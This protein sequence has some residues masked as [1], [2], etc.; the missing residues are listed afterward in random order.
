MRLNKLDLNQLIVLDAM[1]SERSVKRAAERLFLSPPAAS[2][3]LARLRDYFKDELL[4]Q[5][6]KTMVLTPKAESM[7]KPVRDVL[8]QIQALITADPS[9]DPMT[10]TRKITIEASDYVMNVFLAE[11]LRQ[12]WH[13]AP[14]MQFDLR[15]IGT[16][17]HS[18]LDNG[19]VDLLIG[20]DFFAS[21]GH[22]TEQLFQDTW[23]CLTWVGNVSVGADLSLDEYLQLGH[24]I[25]EWGAGRL[26]TSDERVAAKLDYVRRKEVMAPNFTVVPQLLLGTPRIA[27]VQTRLAKLLALSYPLRLSTCPLPMPPLTE[28]LQ[29]HKHQEHDPAIVWFRSLLRRVAGTLLSGAPS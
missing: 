5:I 21:P 27:T 10:S 8:L 17:S 20:P 26:T 2:C 12:A 9:F 7:Q 6:G 25:I 29:W 28:M 22:P 4:V 16:H 3:A 14:R 19:E 23:S 1:L 15:L 24:V 11:V 13:E 18:D